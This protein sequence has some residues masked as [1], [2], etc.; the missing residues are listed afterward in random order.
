[1]P[2]LQVRDFP[3]DVYESLTKVA[4]EDNRS[5]SQETIVLLRSALNQKEERFSRRRRV[6]EE[7]DEMN[8]GDT[9]KFPDPVFLIRKDRDR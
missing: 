5:I 1:M 4:K 6:L 8:L 2:L 9:N 7:I 3:E